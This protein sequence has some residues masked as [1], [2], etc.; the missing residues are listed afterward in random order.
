MPE[1][2][3]AVESILVVDDDDP[4]RLSL[5]RAL[6]RRRLTPYPAASIAEAVA[7][8]EGKSLTY[9]AIDLRIGKDNGVD[10]VRILREIS[11]STRLVLLTGYGNIA[12]AVIAIKAGADDYLPKP[13]DPDHLLAVLRGEEVTGVPATEPEPMTPE[14][15]RWEHIQRILGECSGNISETARR[16]KMHRKTLQRILGKHAPT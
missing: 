9:A 13:V 1:P 16:L 4:F 2:A 12:S 6:Q 11:P 5:C 10:L 3:A 14:R 8:A 7:I 15:V